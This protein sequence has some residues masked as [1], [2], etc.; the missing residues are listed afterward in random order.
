MGV[1]EFRDRMNAIKDGADTKYNPMSEPLPNPPAYH[2]SFLKAVRYCSELMEGAAPVPKNAEYKD[3]RILQLPEKASNSTK[4][5][6][7]KPRIVGLI[8][9][10]GVGKSSLI[11]CLLDTPDIALSGANGEACTNVI[12]E[13]H[14]AQ[15]SQRTV[16]AGS[17]SDYIKHK[18]GYDLSE[19]IP[20]SVRTTRIPHVRYSLSKLPARSRLDALKHYCH[21][22]VEDLIG[23]LCNWSQQSTTQRRVE[24]Q[25]VV[26][27]PHAVR[28][29][30]IC[31][32]LTDI[33]LHRVW[34]L[35]LRSTLQS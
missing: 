34:E 1:E 31:S 3:T 19:E 13:Y 26:A 9:D 24:L 30:R 10:S 33:Y 8:G 12:T 5:E 2:P 16:F 28:K 25:R 32:H 18:D 11:N 35:K 15:P 23:S 17:N 6:Y 4:F 14:Q 22:T 20:V 27:Q 21:G 7:P 29:H